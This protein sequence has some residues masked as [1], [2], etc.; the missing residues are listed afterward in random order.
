MNDLEILL[1]YH[2][3]GQEKPF[4][5]VPFVSPVDLNSRMKDG[6]VASPSLAESR[7]FLDPPEL[8]P[9][10]RWVGLCSP[11]W[12]EK[13]PGAPRI[14]DLESSLQLSSKKEG[15]APALIDIHLREEGDMYSEL[16]A[17]H[18]GIDVPLV[19]FAQHFALSLPENTRAPWSN[20]FVVHREVYEDLLE[21]WNKAYDWAD[22]VWGLDIPFGFRCYECGQE[23]DEQIGRYGSYR[24]ASFFYERVSMLFFATRPTNW[25]TLEERKGGELLLYKK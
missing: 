2:E 11:R 8:K 18:P 4:R 14:Q 17:N 23:S 12:S 21:F 7:L 1:A 20:N 13:W 6:E 3:Q 22:S 9:E 15:Y 16:I 25:V 19:E 10:T 24:Q 5:E